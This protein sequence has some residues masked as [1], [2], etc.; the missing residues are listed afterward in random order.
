ML[1]GV[2]TIIKEQVGQFTL[3]R[4]LARYEVKSSNAEKKL[5]I[6]WEL[7]NPALQVLI[8]WF[9]F[10]VGLRGNSEVNG[11]PFI[12]WLI[13]GLT[14]WFFINDSIL[15]GSN[16]INTRLGMLMKMK[17]PLSVIPSYVV[18]SRLYQHF[19]MIGITILLTLLSVK[20]IPISIIQLPYYICATVVFV[21]SVSL[22]LS[23]LITLV[24]DIHHLLQS[25]LRMLFYVTPILWTVDSFPSYLH[26]WLMLNPIMYLIEGYRDSLITGTFFYEDPLY[27]A[28]FWSVTVFI[29][30][31]GAKLHI[32]FRNSFSELV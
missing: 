7:I 12:I 5:G 16:S 19:A 4:R 29:F 30:V 10:G 22:L 26:G 15:R 28:Y 1:N 11:V 25:L 23:S 6:L 13:V 31:L 18:A 14:P 8:Y 24:K 17:F 20:T 21:Y 27:T 9:V 2:S 32:K 3:I